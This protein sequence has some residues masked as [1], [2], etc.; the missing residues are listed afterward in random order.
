M[1]RLGAFAGGIA[2]SMPR[3]VARWL[4][5]F[6]WATLAWVALLAAWGWW[7]G[8]WLLSMLMIGW[9]LAW[10]AAVIGLQ[11]VL[12]A[13]E[14]RTGGPSL[15]SSGTI[16]KAW[17]T[18]S[19]LHAL[20]FNWRQPFRA[21]AIAD[22]PAPPG[23]MDRR[24][25]VLVHGYFCNRA[26]WNPWLERLRRE[27]VPFIAVNLE[28]PM[29]SIDAHADTIARAVTAL[30]T[31]TGQPP[32]VVAHSMGGL[33]VRAWLR[34]ER[35]AGEPAPRA[36]HIVTIGTP[37]HG[38]SIAQWSVSGNARQMQR[39]SRW[40]AELAASEPGDLGRRFTCVHG[41]CDNIVMPPGTAVLPG[42]REVHIDGTPHIALAFHPTTEALVLGLLRH[43][44]ATR[45][46]RG[47]ASRP[48][49]A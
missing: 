49:P 34:Q 8:W 35:A 43:P 32:L 22:Q 41:R 6:V 3:M 10:P 20:T 48:P 11:Y 28:P 42:S 5:A 27:C 38:T 4:R 33:A 40:L 31:A 25:V 37:H 30:T 44:P 14:V 7:S 24:G 46:G 26:F 45:P 23:S 17:W 15:P 36:S 21:R 1:A 18:E 2:G 9:A 16:I 29:A 12:L 39:G 13:S 19:A 47:S